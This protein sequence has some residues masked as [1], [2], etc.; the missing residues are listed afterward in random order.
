MGKHKDTKSEYNR[1]GFNRDGINQYTKN[2]I[3][4]IWF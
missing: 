4:E 3:I 1:D 2:N